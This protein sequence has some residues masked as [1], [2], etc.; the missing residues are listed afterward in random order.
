MSDRT[1]S[2]FPTP[3][4]LFFAPFQFGLAFMAAQAESAQSSSLLRHIERQ[5]AEERARAKNKT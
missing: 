1:P 4:S 2:A 3:A 5:R